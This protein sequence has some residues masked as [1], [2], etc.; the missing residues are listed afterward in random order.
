MERFLFPSTHN[1]SDRDALKDIAKTTI[2]AVNRGEYTIHD[3]IYM[4]HSHAA[5]QG[6]RF[7]DHDSSSLS[8]WQSSPS[9]LFGNRRSQQSHISILEIST[10]RCARLLTNILRLR[11][12]NSRKVGVL[13]FASAT[14]PGGGF[15]NGA[16]AQEESIA[17]SSTLYPT[18]VSHVAREFYEIH[19]DDPTNAFYT[20]SIIY[21]PDVE[22]FRDDDGGWT[23]P[24][25]IEVLTCAAVNA[26][27]V[28]GTRNS[29]P[30]GQST[31][32]RIRS[33]MG[34]RMARILYLFEKKGVRNLVLGSFGTGVFR[35][36]VDAIAQIWA[37][38]L[39][40]PSARFGKSFD[41]V[42]FA[43]MGRQTFVEFEESFNGRTR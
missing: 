21:S 34:E 6:T 27:E 33:V 4:L 14:K 37:D 10:L 42:M 39:S 19:N 18:L 30:A 41:R 22:V 35:N 13:N 40:G 31:E 3:T 20:H 1:H 7:F 9:V 15:L 11:P 32:G 25:S 29:V 36:D 26:G 2:R 43:I 8:N 28:R 23:K 12:A 5:V 38:L 16:Q 24:M 17:R